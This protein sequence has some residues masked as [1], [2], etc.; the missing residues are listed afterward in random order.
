MHLRPRK[1]FGP[2]TKG[3]EGAGERSGQSDLVGRGVVDGRVHRVVVENVQ[4]LAVVRPRDELDVAVLRVE[5]KIL[6]VERAVRFDEGRVHPQH[7]A[8]TRPGTSTA[9]CRHLSRSRSS[10]CSR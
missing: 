3:R 9:P 1:R 2:L 5:R 4:L 6:D 8:V 7:R 10:P